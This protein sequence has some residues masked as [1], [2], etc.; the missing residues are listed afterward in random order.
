MNHHG[1][2]LQTALDRLERRAA[3]RPLGPL[4]LGVALGAASLVAGL[5]LFLA[6]FIALVSIVR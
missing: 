1:E 4:L 3:A 2:A 6:V 5:L